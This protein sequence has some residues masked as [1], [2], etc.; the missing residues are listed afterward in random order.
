MLRRAL[1]ASVVAALLVTVV[2]AAATDPLDPKVK[3]VQ[4]DQAA[5]TAALIRQSDLGTGWA[6]GPTTPTNFKA[7]RCP[8]LQPNF[9]DLTVTGHAEAFFHLDQAGWQIDSD[10]TVLKSATQVAAQYKRLFQPKLTTCIKYDV[11]KST[12]ADPNV[13]LGITKRLD[14]PKVAPIVAFYRT[15]IL[16]QVGKRT[17]EVYDDT[18]MLSKNRTQFWINIVAPSSDRGPLE[19]REQEIARTLVKRV[20][21]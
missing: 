3:I 16:Y 18:L 1:G 4:S 2:A 17:V 13:H 6:G 21:V 11:L 5:A 10:V 12:G 20:R 15:S 7:P 19:L 14:F 8:A 9:H